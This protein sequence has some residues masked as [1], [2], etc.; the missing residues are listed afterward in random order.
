MGHV[1]RITPNRYAVLMRAWNCCLYYTCKKNVFYS[2][3]IIEIIIWQ[4]SYHTPYQPETPVS[5]RNSRI[6]PRAE[7][8]RGL[9]WESRVV[10][11]YDMKIVIS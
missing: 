11:G 6:S 8:N 1:G 2:K 7:G 4:F 3:Y 5:D 9:I 10:T